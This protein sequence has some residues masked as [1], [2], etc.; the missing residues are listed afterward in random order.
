MVFCGVVDVPIGDILPGGH[1]G[2][3]QRNIQ[4]AFLVFELFI[5]F[6]DIILKA[7]NHAIYNDGRH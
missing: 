3:V 5:T 1:I 7:L 6:P 2:G 4:P